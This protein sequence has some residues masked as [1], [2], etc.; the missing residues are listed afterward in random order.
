MGIM[1]IIAQKIKEEIVKDPENVGYAGKTD[2]EIT[3]MLNSPVKR[4]VITEV[5]EQPPINRILSGIPETPNVVEAKDVI[6]AKAIIVAVE[7]PI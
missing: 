5:Q 6:A 2:D 1:D 4:V 3:I 7:E